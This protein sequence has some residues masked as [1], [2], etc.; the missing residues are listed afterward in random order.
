MANYDE[1][2]GGILTLA[3][4]GAVIYGVMNY[5]IISDTKLQELK[6]QESILEETQADVGISKSP[7]DSITYPTFTW[8]NSEEKTPQRIFISGT[9]KNS[10]GYDT[11]ITQSISCFRGMKICSVSSIFFE[12]QGTFTQTAEVGIIE[13]WDRETVVFVTYNPCT[14]TTYKINLLKRIVE[15]VKNINEPVEEADC[16]PLSPDDYPIISYLTKELPLIPN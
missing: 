5:N 9:V 7:R 16:I 13:K 11:Y 8:T 1:L 2:F 4:I 15:Q 10:K 6:N 14:E 3:G 12:E